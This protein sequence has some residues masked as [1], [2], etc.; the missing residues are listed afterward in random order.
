MVENIVLEISLVVNIKSILI[1][2]FLLL[3]T[4]LIIKNFTRGEVCPNCK[5]ASEL[6]RVKKNKLVNVIPYMKTIRIICGNCQRKHYRVVNKVKKK[7]RTPFKQ[8]DLKIQHVM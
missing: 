4:F 3:I 2:F 7:N 1:L 6:T 5:N 8:F